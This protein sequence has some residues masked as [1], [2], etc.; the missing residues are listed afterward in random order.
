MIVTV[1]KECNERYVGCHGKREDGSWRCQRWGE[2]QEEKAEERR[3]TQGEKIQKALMERYAR[4]NR[5]R[6]MKRKK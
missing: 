2:A 1:C 3:R 4:E 5:F 6:V